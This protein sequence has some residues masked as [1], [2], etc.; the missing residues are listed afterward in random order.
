MLSFFYKERELKFLWYPV[1]PIGWSEIFVFL[2][3][4]EPVGFAV[5]RN[6]EFEV[7]CM[8]R[9]VAENFIGNV[10]PVWRDYK[11]IGVFDI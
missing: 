3:D 8:D 10:P 9:R 4:G 7:Y 11:C 6:E 2:N 5:S 1:L